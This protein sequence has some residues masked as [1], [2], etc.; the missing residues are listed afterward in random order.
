MNVLPAY[1]CPRCESGTHGS[2]KKVLDALE[3]E[4]HISL[5]HYVAA[6]S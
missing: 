6:G 3:H 1:M 4:L 5:I 2:Q